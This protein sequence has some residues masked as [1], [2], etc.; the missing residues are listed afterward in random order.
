M[1]FAADIGSLAIV[2]GLWPSA[3]AHGFGRQNVLSLALGLA[4]SQGFKE[5]DLE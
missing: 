5:S 3:R 4:P 1:I 2:R